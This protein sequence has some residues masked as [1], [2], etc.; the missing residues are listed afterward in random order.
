[1][2]ILTLLCYLHI[3]Y[4]THT[5][6]HWKWLGR[7]HLV[8]FRVCVRVLRAEIWVRRIIFL[9]QVKNKFIYAVSHD[10]VFIPVVLNVLY[11]LTIFFLEM[12]C[13]RFKCFL[14]NSHQISQGQVSYTV[15]FDQ[16]W[17]FTCDHSKRWRSSHLC[18]LVVSKLCDLSVSLICQFCTLLLVASTSVW[19]WRVLLTST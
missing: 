17:C 10:T 3:Y 7:I 2:Y 15:F 8:P 11:M 12:M 16:M 1:M 6:R 19:L 13:Y 18:R 5:L 14:C 4:N 9:S